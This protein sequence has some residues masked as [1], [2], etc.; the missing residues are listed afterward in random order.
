MKLKLPN[1]IGPM[2][3]QLYTTRASRTLSTLLAA[4][5]GVLMPLA[6][7][8]MSQITF[9]LIDLWTDDGRRM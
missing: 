1:V 3:S 8:E 4:G 6:F 2:F 5:V 9:S 7:A